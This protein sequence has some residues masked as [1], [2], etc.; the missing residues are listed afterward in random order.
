ML[1]GVSLDQ[2]R[3]FIAAA[4]EGSFSAAGRRLKRAQSFVSQTL[5]NLEDRLGV[6][7]FDRTARFPVLTDQGRALLADARAVT[8]QMDLLKARAKSLAGGCEA[9]LTVVV[10]AIFPIAIL[11]GAIDALR[12]QFPETSLRLY[13]KGSGASVQHVLDRRCAVGVVV[14]D[15]SMPP[16]LARERLMTVNMAM[17]VS[18]KHPLA[19]Y[20]RPIPATALTKH[21]QLVHTDRLD[22][23]PGREF[24]LL[25]PKTWLLAH[26]EAK[27]AFLRAGFGFGGLPH[28]VVE[29][30]LASG[31]LVQISTEEP[32]VCD[33]AIEMSALYRIDSPPGPATRWLIKRLMQEDGARLGKGAGVSPC[34]VKPKSSRAPPPKR[35]AREIGAAAL[36]NPQS[37]SA[38]QSSVPGEDQ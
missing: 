22:L 4:D 9:E 13:V 21:I 7:L 25:S 29:R 36:L 2:L 37:P 31:D 26:I 14:S 16:Q 8:G 27:L 32:H 20:R 1:D 30:D 18:P 5:S 11:I 19:A 35:F 28:H 24:D 15:I 10:D 34:A 23:L 12:V 38:A 6:R 17:V 33:R 3:T